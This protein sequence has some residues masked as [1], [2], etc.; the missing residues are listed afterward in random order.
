MFFSTCLPQDPKL[1]KPVHV[2]LGH[3][4]SNRCDIYADLLQCYTKLRTGRKGT[5]QTQIV[6]LNR[7]WREE[8]VKLEAKQKAGWSCFGKIA[9]GS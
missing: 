9:K 2:S 1:L 6:I 8:T 7:Q 5:F 3:L 4:A